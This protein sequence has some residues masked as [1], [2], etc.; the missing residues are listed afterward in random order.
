MLTKLC[1]RCGIEK[2]LDYFHKHS[3]TKDGRQPKCKACALEMARDNYRKNP[4]RA[5]ASAKRW[6][7]KNPSRRKEIAYNSKLKSNYGI[8]LAGYQR[9]LEQQDGKCAIC[10][11]EGG[12]GRSEVFKLFVDHCHTTGKIRGLLCMKCNSGL[13]YF[14][15]DIMKMKSAIQYLQGVMA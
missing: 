9:M 3:K 12:A 8:E 2:S 11:G 10:G 7:E 13:G 1:Q 4:E 5:S 15:D 14:E 6:A